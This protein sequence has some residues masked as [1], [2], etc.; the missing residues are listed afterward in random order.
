MSVPTG[1]RPDRGTHQAT[2]AATLVDEWVR[3]GVTHAVV[4]PGSRSAPL[5]LALAERHE[6]TVH[7]RLDERSAGFF[8]L[9][10]A[11]ATGRPTVV[12]VTSGTAAAELHP[13]VLEAHHAGVALLVCTADRPPELQQV[14]AP[15]TVEQVGLY[16][17][18][19]RWAV[20][21]GPADEAGPPWWRSLGARAVLEA[22]AGP[23]GPGPVHLNLAFR[24]PLDAVAGPLPPG[25]PDG[26]PWHRATGAAAASAGDPQAWVAAAPDRGV[27]VAGAGAG[28]PEPVL[29]LGRALGWPVLADPRSGARTDDDGV[30]A[31]ADA[32]LRHAGVA[33]SLVPQAVLQLG[34]PWCSKVL[35]AW[36]ARAAASGVPVTAV[37]PHWRWRDPDHVLAD[38]RCAEP[39]AWLGA[40]VAAATGG[41]AGGGGAGAGEWRRR[42]A[43]AERAA[44]Q[45]IDQVLGVEAGPRT[46]AGPLSE[47]SLARCLPTLLVPGSTLVVASSM[48][49]RDLEW[50]APPLD[51]PPPVVANRGV[52]GIDGVTSTA[53]GV[54]AAGAGPVV[55]L[56]GDLA[57]LHDVSGLVRLAGS[58]GG[59]SPCTLVVIDNGGGG[60]FSFLPQAA[61]VE[62]PRFERLFGTPADVDVA[63]VARGFGLPVAEVDTAAALGEALAADRDGPAGGVSVI[64]AAVPDRAANVALHDRLNREA[65]LAA[66]A[67]L[68]V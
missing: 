19:V 3:A 68:G 64:R 7:V 32:F 23:H 45:A 25:R 63:A 56:L 37:D 47:P 21:P 9:G 49:V 35:G 38:V 59:G 15:Q 54:A 34:A 46:A 57:F 66:A 24:D 50:F 41:T 10:L 42:W 4:C 13:A 48:P 18:A 55:G 11:L 40:A 31:A 62:A 27:I 51:T 17:G 61:S 2:F 12:G 60:I 6:L 30:V 36:V 16:G 65:G 58:P 44:Q 29:A 52:N 53:L 20:S 5:A 26:T 8:A 1:P 39:A 33:G 43:A 67:A 14:G 22:T 28:P